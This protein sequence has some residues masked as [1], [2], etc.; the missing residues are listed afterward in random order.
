MMRSWTAK[1]K[2]S[3]KAER[4]RDDLVLELSSA[5]GLPTYSLYPK[6]GLNASSRV[7]TSASTISTPT[8]ATSGV[9]QNSL[10]ESQYTHAEPPQTWQATSSTVAFQHTTPSTS[11]SSRRSSR[12]RTLSRVSSQ[13]SFYRSSL[14]DDGDIRT[15]VGEAQEGEDGGGNSQET[16]NAEERSNGLTQ[17]PSATSHRTQPNP[18]SL[19]RVVD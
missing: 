3:S 6:N 15:Q 16:M 17:D 4:E 8:S 9:S 14:D 1:R 18:R 11:S 7:S 19:C 12:V 5:L 2:S 10:P 13:R